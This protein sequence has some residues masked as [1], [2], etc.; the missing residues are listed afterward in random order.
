MTSENPT[1]MQTRS[2]FNTPVM[3]TIA[4]VVFVLGLVVGSGMLTP[5]AFAQQEKQADFRP[6]NTPVQI[7]QVQ[8]PT[9]QIENGTFTWAVVGAADGKYYVIDHCGIARRAELESG[10][11][12]YWR[13]P[14]IE[15]TEINI[16]AR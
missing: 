2:R 4:G 15:A 7:Y 16:D 9:A 5:A 1:T 8:P 10:G 13:D 3:F 12:V 11:D 6:E 14:L